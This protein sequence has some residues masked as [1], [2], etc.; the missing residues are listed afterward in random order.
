[1]SLLTPI[2]MPLGS[3]HQGAD[4][5][6]KAGS[7]ARQVQALSG[8]DAEDDRLW[9]VAE[10]FEEIFLNMMLKQMRK[11]TFDSGLLGSGNDAKIY[12][13]MFDSEVSRLVSE[14]RE[15]GLGKMVHD[16]LAGPKSVYEN[17][18]EVKNPGT[19]LDINT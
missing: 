4:N 5:D 6:A 17:P 19:K 10:G 12:Q 18:G 13:E 7:L 9:K 2:D 15:F 3:I 14:R 1:M 16:F 11:T 8:S